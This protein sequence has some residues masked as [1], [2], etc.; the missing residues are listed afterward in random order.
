MI[1]LIQSLLE[2]TVPETAELLRLADTQQKILYPLKE[3]AYYVIYVYKYRT[4]C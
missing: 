4:V 3:V 1:S 2:P